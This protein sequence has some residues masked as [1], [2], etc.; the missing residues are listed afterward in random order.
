MA[1]DN[2]DGWDLDEFL[3]GYQ[4]RRKTVTLYGRGDLVDEHARLEA[5]LVQV[6]STADVD[7]GDADRV[8]DI[9]DRIKTAEAELAASGREFTVEAC[10]HDEWYRLM[11][12]HPPSE[13]ERKSNPNTAVGAVFQAHAVARCVVTPKVTITQA[14]RMRAEMRPDDFDRLWMAVIECVEGGVEVPKSGLATAVAKLFDSSS[15]PPG[16]RASRRRS[17]SAGAAAR[18]KSTRTTKKAS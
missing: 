2:G 17:S 18:S 1:D 10:S 11:V 13:A 16:N 5:E 4:R 3:D 8:R 7:D 15:T 14:K 12:D 9:L 6:G